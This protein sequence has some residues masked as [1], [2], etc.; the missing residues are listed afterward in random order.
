MADTEYRYQ[1]IDT[2][3]PIPIFLYRYFHRPIPFVSIFLAPI[4]VSISA[5]DGKL[6]NLNLRACKQKLLNT[7]NG[8]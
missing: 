7:L 3:F 2:F 1:N 8:Q 4:L 5:N 6:S